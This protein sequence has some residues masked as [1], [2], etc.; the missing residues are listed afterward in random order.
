MVVFKYIPN[1]LKDEGR[2]T[3]ELP[4]VVNKPLKDYLTE[5]GFELSD[6][7]IIVTGAVAEDLTAILH[8]GDEIIITPN[9]GFAFLGNP[10][11][12]AGM[13]GFVQS[14]GITVLTLAYS[15]YSAFQ[16]PKTPNFGTNGEGLDEGS[17]TY[18]WEGISNTQEIGLPIG[19]VYGEHRV[20]G[21]RMIKL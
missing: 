14:Y 2:I 15:I 9:V 10:A 6:S 5:T 18:G 19:I 17:P 13:W 8:N 4:F 7:K 16:K 1:I 12:W 20:G 11:F 3:N 21:N